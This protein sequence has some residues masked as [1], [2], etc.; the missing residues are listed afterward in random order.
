MIWKLYYSNC[1]SRGNT[2][3]TVKRGE[4]NVSY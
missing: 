3:D 1:I 4:E 2:V